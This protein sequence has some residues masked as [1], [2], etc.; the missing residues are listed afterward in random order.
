MVK[1]GDEVPGVDDMGGPCVTEGSFFVHQYFGSW[2]RH[3]SSIEV[4]D[5]IEE[6]VGGKFWVEARGTEDIQCY[7]RHR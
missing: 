2:G 3:W 5:S 7:D 4:V 1:G 6:G